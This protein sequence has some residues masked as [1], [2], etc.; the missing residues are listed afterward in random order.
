MASGTLSSNITSGKIM[1]PHGCGKMIM[2]DATLKIKQEKL[3]Y[4][5][6]YSVYSSI[7]QGVWKNTI[8]CT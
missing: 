5:P 1:H 2:L 7:C 3:Y 8:L 4:V 6:I